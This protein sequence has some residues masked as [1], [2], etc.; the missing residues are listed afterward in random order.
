M[1]K[2]IES[3][4][5]FCAEEIEPQTA[6]VGKDWKVYCT[7]ACAQRGEDLSVR[8]LTQLMRYVSDRHQQ[9]PVAA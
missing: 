7:T 2:R 6:I 8:E 1:A 5:A 4:C 9:L 3:E